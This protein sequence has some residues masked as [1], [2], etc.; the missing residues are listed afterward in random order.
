MPKKFNKAT[1]KSLENLRDELAGDTDV[2]DRII[3]DAADR[4]K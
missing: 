1:K 2:I 4:R 3:N